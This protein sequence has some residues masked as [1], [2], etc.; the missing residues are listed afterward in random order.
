[1][2]AGPVTLLALYVLGIGVWSFLE[3]VIHGW[4]SHTLATPAG[5]LHWSHHRDPRRVFT[6]VVVWAPASV[7]IWGLV[8]IALGAAPAAA[9]VLGI[10]SGFLRYEYVH[11]RIHF[12][13]P[14]NARQELLRLHHLAHHFRNP[15]AYHGVTTRLFDRLFGTLPPDHRDDYTRVR[16]HVPLGGASNLGSLWPRRAR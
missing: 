8:A 9:L 7:A 15:K 12:R 3:Y 1:V 5:P 10:L 14:R 6:S 13:A 2:L 16:H 4:L 11:W